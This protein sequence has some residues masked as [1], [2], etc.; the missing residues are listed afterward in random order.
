MFYADW[1]VERLLGKEE[2]LSIY[3]FSFPAKKFKQN[4]KSDSE[5]YSEH[6]KTS[7]RNFFAKILNSLTIFAKTAI[8]DG[9]QG[10]E[11]DME[12]I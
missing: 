4:Y 9:W 11:Y 7:Q 3:I 1:E 5:V 2:K 8:L 12:T 10:S 6:F